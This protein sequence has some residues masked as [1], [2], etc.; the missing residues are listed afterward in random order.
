MDWVGMEQ[1]GFIHCYLPF[2]KCYRYIIKC[3]ILIKLW[4]NLED[5]EFK[6]IHSVQWKNKH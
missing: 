4:V 2:V 6:A 5:T 3:L 1:V